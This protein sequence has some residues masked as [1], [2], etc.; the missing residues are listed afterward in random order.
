MTGLEKRVK[1]VAGVLTDGLAKR[2][3]RSSGSVLG[4]TP[5]SGT[6]ISKDRS[7]KTSHGSLASLGISE[8]RRNAKK[9]L[10]ISANTTKKLRMG[11][12]EGK[13]VR[14]TGSSVSLKLFIA[15][16]MAVLVPALQM[17][18]VL[19]AKKLQALKDLKKPAM[20]QP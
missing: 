16:A 7:G 10:K 14:V 2:H 9:S 5:I 6:R 1:E 18:I 8:A 4:W 17:P 13:M 12:S 3:L 15:T 19:L 11:E 20:Q